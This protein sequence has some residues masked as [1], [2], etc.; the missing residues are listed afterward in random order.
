MTI[1]IVGAGA[2]GSHLIL[3]ARNWPCTLKVLDFDRVETKNV[4]SQ[5]H[6]K[7][8]M[9]RNKAQGIQ[10]AMQGMFGVKIEAVPHKLVPENVQAL[11][12]G[13]GLVIDCTDNAEARRCIQAFVRK[14]N[15]PCLHGCLSASGDFAQIVWD[16]IFKEDEEGTPGQPTCENGDNLPFHAF[17]A[18]QIAIV[19]QKFLK[20][21]IKR[22]SMLI[23][24]KIIPLN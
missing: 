24:D 19:A 23:S 21:G 13:A 11:L 1:V 16:E 17:A 3:L 22:S 7:M 9:G 20:T 4:M 14:T 12:G 2:L 5:F 18:A 15:T 8:G 6:T 10:Q